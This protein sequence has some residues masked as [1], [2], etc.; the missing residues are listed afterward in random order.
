MKKGKGRLSIKHKRQWERGQGGVEVWM[1]GGE[2]RGRMG[3]DYGR[4]RMANGGKWPRFKQEAAYDG[5]EIAI[6]IV[7]Q[8]GYVK[9]S[10]ATCVRLGADSRLAGLDAWYEKGSIGWVD[11]EQLQ[12]IEALGRVAPADSEE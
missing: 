10:A 9:S 2:K 6:I 4:Q 1:E 5:A 11:A 8:E 3:P 7:G 12:E